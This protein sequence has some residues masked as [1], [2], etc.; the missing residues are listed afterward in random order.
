MAAGLRY[1]GRDDLGLIA[2]DRPAD[3]AGV[4][5]KSTTA[6]HP[7]VWCRQ[8]LANRKCSAVIVNAGN[9][10]VFRGVE[11]DLAVHAE[12]R[13]VAQSLS[14][15]TTEVFVASTG[16]IGERLPV[17]MLC[18]AI[19]DLVAGL[20][21]SGIEAFAQAI[22]TTDTFAKW[23][24][25]ELEIDGHH[26]AI[27]GAAKGSGM[28]APDMATMLAFVVTD[29]AIEARLLQQLLSAANERTF[30][31]ITVDSDTST[32]DTLLIAATGSAGHATISSQHDSR[33]AI[34]AE[35]LERVLRDLAL[36]VVRDGE[37]AEKLITVHCDGAKDDPS[38]KRI[39]MS[40]A[41]SPLVKTAI[42][43]ADS[44]WGRIVMAIGKSGEAIESSAISIAFGGHPVAQD[45]GAIADLDETPVAEHLS[46]NDIQINLTVGRGA[47]RATVWTCDLTHAYIDINAD[48]RS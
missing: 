26:V 29:A 44:N 5:T 34:F 33:T 24:C 22:M 46:G 15:E 13:S 35:A 12:A 11:G 32:S 21:R 25:A 2:F 19:P 23:A 20:R 47:G 16:V 4:F 8:I 17:E 48:Y 9:A 41:N 31:C 39:A 28:I 37:G 45:G 30:N 40:V 14:C 1:R 36:M 42:A 10:N 3:V 27:A 38:A 18:A 6:G 43:G 7:V